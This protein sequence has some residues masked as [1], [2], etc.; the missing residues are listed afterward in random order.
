MADTPE[1]TA[2]KKL[3][4]LVLKKVDDARRDRQKR[5]PLIN[6]TYRLA[7]PWR[8]QV[9]SSAVAAKDQPALS[10][11]DIADI[12]DATLAET[13]SDFASDMISQFTP[14]SEPWTRFKAKEGVPPEFK[15][16]VDELSAKVETA[17]FEAIAE[18]T[19]FDAA[20]QCFQELANGTMAARLRMP[21]RGGD[22]F[23]V[24]PIE[25]A[26]LLLCN[27]PTRGMTDGRFTEGV[28]PYSEFKS[29][30]GKYAKLPVGKTPPKPDD[31]V[32]VVDGFYRVWENARGD[33]AWRRCVLLNGDLVFEQFVADDPDV[34]VIV[35][36]WEVN[37]KSAWGVGPAFRAHP[38][39]RGLNEIMAIMMVGAGKHA[40]TPGFYTDD[41][42]VNLEQGF[43][44][45]DMIPTGP[46]F[47][48]KWWEPGGQLDVSF[49][50]EQEFRQ[51]I[52]HALF[53]DKP[54]QKGKTPPTAEQWQSLE[55][56]SRQRWEIPRGK[57]VREWVLPIVLWTKRYLEKTGQLPPEY[58][59]DNRIF[60]IV[61]NSPFAKA[62][63]QEEFVRANDLLRTFAGYS[64]QT[65]PMDVDISATISNLKKALNDK[66]VVVRSPED[67]QK[68]M[69]LMQSQMQG[70][71]QQPGAPANGP[72]E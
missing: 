33:R 68:I 27:S 39:Q 63:E 7:A 64:S 46:E 28:I 11:E 18:S 44:A 47:D 37:G 24:E 71:Q 69:E 58:K 55:V 42:V 36:R 4:K 43:E 8:R 38:A 52:R 19:Y 51:T 30:Y 16:R 57:I 65:F 29:L 23:T 60:Q 34:D 25:P 59:V 6:E 14:D 40:D 20:P 41:G 9:Q 2:R 67:R 15:V 10:D 49:F 66:L 53:Q 50:T 26:D 62:R 72:T 1:E 13:Q 31:D 56:R 17:V 54:E 45:G 12:V 21:D 3:Q 32:T 5:A 35:A 48:V 70:G 22:P 61:P